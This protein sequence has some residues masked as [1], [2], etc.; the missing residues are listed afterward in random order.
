MKDIDDLAQSVVS[1]RVELD[2]A[3]QDKRRRSRREWELR[4]MRTVAELPTGGLSVVIAVGFRRVA[5]CR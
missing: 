3:L 5:A 1:A 4:V 2:V